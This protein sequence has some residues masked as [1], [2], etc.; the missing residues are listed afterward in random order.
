[1]ADSV[2]F[3]RIAV[4]GTGLIGGSFALAVRA[5]F[6]A[7]E[8]VGWDR[9]SVSL[10][11]AVERGAVQEKAPDL[12]GAVRRADLVYV[13]L[14][15][16]AIVK[17]LAPIAEGAEHHVLVTDTGST[18]VLITHAATEC[19]RGKSSLFLG[20]H[21][22]AGKEN[23]GIESADAE[24]FKGASYALIANEDEADRRVRDF[25]ALVAGIGA[26]VV[27]CDADTHD[28]SV[29]VVSH[30]PQMLSI[31]LARVIEDETEDTG[32]PL[33]LA[34]QGLTDSL[35]L[36]GSPYP[37]WRDILFSNSDNVAHAL[38]RLAQAVE[39]LQRNLKSAELEQ[40]FRAANELY[41]RLR[42]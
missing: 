3:R 23:S 35:R 40:E 1:M 14:P 10:D 21:P 24:L 11:R 39:H 15:V 9:D 27:W 20:G 25:A 26:R 7:V 13:A 33:A 22:M 12:A 30:L 37:V 28:W 31:A 34:G 42:K 16:R 18:K 17:S 6:P 36:A 32:F 2:P 38:N 41:K 5:N 29:G 4:I 8:V 19:F